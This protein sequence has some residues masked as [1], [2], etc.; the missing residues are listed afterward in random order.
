[1]RRKVPDS[2]LVSA[3]RQTRV[4]N[5]FKKLPPPR[6][7]ERLPREFKKSEQPHVRRRRGKDSERTVRG[8]CPYCKTDCRDA[9]MSNALE[10]FR[11]GAKTFIRN[12]T[13]RESRPALR[14]FTRIAKYA[15]SMSDRFAP[16]ARKQSNPA[17]WDRDRDDQ[18]LHQSVSEEGTAGEKLKQQQQE[19]YITVNYEKQINRPS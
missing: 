5:P 15:C 19:P 18:T 16:G 17:E 10:G 13:I 8:I 4:S 11:A 6:G 7:G 1:M 2:P 12:G 3:A 14:V 9:L